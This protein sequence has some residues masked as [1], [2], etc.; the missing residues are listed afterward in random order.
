[1]RT[2]FICLV[3][4][5]SASVTAQ[6][7]KIKVNIRPSCQAQ[8]SNAANNAEI[9]TQCSA[10]FQLAKLETIKDNRRTITINY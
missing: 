8:W 5:I 4:V 2:L 1:M 3:V 10:G 9:R 6:E 7:A